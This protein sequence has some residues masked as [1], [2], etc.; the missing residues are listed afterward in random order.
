MIRCKGL[1]SRHSRMLSSATI[2]HLILSL[3]L[4]SRCWEDSI[5]P[6]LRNRRNPRLHLHVSCYK[7]YGAKKVSSNRSRQKLMAAKTVRSDCFFLY[8]SFFPAPSTGSASEAEGDRRLRQESVPMQRIPVSS[9]SSLILFHLSS[10]CST[11]PVR[12][13]A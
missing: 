7:R 1:K 3:L 12:I 4:Q 13:P 5:N 9:P 11:R 10:F 2:R 6:Y 8:E